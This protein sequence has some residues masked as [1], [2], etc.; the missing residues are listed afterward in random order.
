M[1]TQ[2]GGGIARV[3]RKGDGPFRYS[4]KVLH[5]GHDTE[6]RI[7]RAQRQALAVR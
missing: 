5:G 1:R 4:L 2:G 6:T 3:G 7:I